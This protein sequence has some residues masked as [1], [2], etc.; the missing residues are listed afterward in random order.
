MLSHSDDRR[1]RR[2]RRLL[3]Q[4]LSELLREKKFSDISA[5]D[6]TERMDLNRGT[7]YLHYADTYDLLQNLEQ[8]VLTNAQEMIDAHRAEAGGDTLRPIFEP[9]LDYIVENRA[10]CRALFVNNASSDFTGKVYQLLYQNGFDLIRRRFP[11]APEKQMEYLLNFIAFGLIGLMREWFDTDMEL[12]K[13]DLLHM[14]DQLVAGASCQLFGHPQMPQ[15]PGG[16][17]EKSL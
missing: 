15:R 9:L 13:D 7:F 16:P 1:A 2:S 11:N 17:S 14:A 6:I 8:D 10:L 3:K 4:G 5:K 12:S